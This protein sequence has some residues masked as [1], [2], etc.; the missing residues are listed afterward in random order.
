MPFEI[1]DLIL[2]GI[3]L[4]SGLLALMRGFTR[5]VLSLVAWG[6]AALAAYFAIKQQP[7]I[8]LARAQD[9][10]QRRGHQQAQGDGC[11]RGGWTKPSYAARLAANRHAVGSMH[12][13]SGWSLR[14]RAS[15][16]PGGAPEKRTYAIAGP[17]TV[18]GTAHRRRKGTQP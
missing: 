6:L 3:M 16:E 13:P 5:E 11:C 15:V 2:I 8:D 9:C 10:R 4:I 14:P 18:R 1:L 17:F 12:A 7:L